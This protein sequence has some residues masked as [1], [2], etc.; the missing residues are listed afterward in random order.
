MSSGAQQEGTCLYITDKTMID[1]LG[2][3][4]HGIS[5]YDKD[6]DVSFYDSYMTF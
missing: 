2:V 4:A 6:F 1:T 5:L 3:E